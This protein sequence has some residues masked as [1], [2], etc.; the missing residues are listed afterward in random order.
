MDRLLVF[1]Y[2]FEDL[3]ELQEIVTMF[4]DDLNHNEPSQ[5]LGCPPALRWCEDKESFKAYDDGQLS[6]Y[7]QPKPE[8]IHKVSKESMVLYEGRKYSVPL[9]SIGHNVILEVS[10]GYL[11]IYDGELLVA[12]HQLTDKP[13]NYRR[14][15][16]LEIA[17][18]DVYSHLTEEAL[19]ARVNQNLLDYNEL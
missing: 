1:N 4:M 17:K 15:D 6:V 10:D 14:E 2:E 16:Y 19:E 11:K 18:S 5:A 3:M 13:F 8:M 7:A 12:E 9:S